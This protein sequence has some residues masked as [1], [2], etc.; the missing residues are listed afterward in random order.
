MTNGRMLLRRI[1]GV[2]TSFLKDDIYGESQLDRMSKK[3]E[4]TW[5]LVVVTFDDDYFDHN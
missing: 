3:Q 4:C 1:D 5:R 2:S